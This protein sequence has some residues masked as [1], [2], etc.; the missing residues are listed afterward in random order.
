M[1]K[2]IKL[3]PNFLTVLRLFLTGFLFWMIMISE[4]VDNRTMFL[5]AAFI[6]FVI[7]GLT[8]I[9]DGYIARRFDAVS[10]FGRIVDPLAD[11]ILICGCFI[12]FAIIGRPIIFD[13][14]T[15]VLTIIHWSVVVILIVRE[16]T[17][18][19]VRQYAEDKGIVFPA[20]VYGKLKM[21]SQSFGVGTVLVK[22]NHLETATWA[23]WFT[24]IVFALIIIT[25]IVSG[26]EALIRLFAEQKRLAKL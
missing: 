3:V 23:N 18:T 5:N 13:W 19:L 2:I 1:A 15:T 26:L 8:D 4:N 16:A 14:N 6:F 17:V 25:T 7:T 20:S 10:K 22:M 9:V 12:C 24:L 11:K 21:F